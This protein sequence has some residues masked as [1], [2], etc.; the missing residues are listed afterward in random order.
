[1]SEIQE[2]TRDRKVEKWRKLQIAEVA[3]KKTENGNR[4][5]EIKAFTQ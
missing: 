1:M 5:S 4:C 3:A 2:V